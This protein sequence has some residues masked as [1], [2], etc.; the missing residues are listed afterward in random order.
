MINNKEVFIKN[1]LPALLMLV[2]V[3]SFSQLPL[4]RE[5]V[6]LQSTSDIYVAGEEIH[7][8]AAVLET[9][10]YKPST[11][12]NNMRVE[13]INNDGELIFQNNY[14][15]SGSQITSSIKLPAGLS[16]GWYHL[17]SY[18]NWMRNFPESD[19]SWLSIRVVQAADLTGK[20][21]R[22]ENDSICILLTHNGSCSNVT[23]TEE[24]SIF[25]S[26]MQGRPLSA[27]GF[28]LSSSTDTVAW[29][30]TDNTGWGVSE[31][32]KGPGD[33]YKPFIQGYAPSKTLLSINEPD[34]EK[35]VIILSDD[36]AFVYV[37]VENLLLTGSY[38][39]LVHKTYSWYW[40]KESHTVTGNIEFAVPKSSLPGGIVQFS[41][42]NN[43]NELLAARLWSDHDLNNTRVKILNHSTRKGLRS[44]YNADYHVNTQSPDNQTNINVLVMKENPFI[45]GNDYLPGLPGWA[46]GY[47]IPAAEDSFR[48]WLMNNSY[49]K[50]IVREFFRSGNSPEIPASSPTGI[51]MEY[52][53][54]T[55]NRLLSGRL[56][57]T[58]DGSGIEE[59]YLGLTILNDGT[60]HACVSD[61]KG[62]FIFS[63]PEITGPVDY[64][65]NYIREPKPEWRIDIDRLYESVRYIPPTDSVKFTE[66]ELKYL[67]EQA[68]I[69]HLKNIYSQ[70]ESDSNKN[71]DEP[72]LTGSDSYFYGMADLKV[73]VDDYIT[74]SNLREVIYEVVPYVSIRK[75]GDYTIP[76]I[77]GDHLHASLY[78]S[79]V[80]FDGIPVYDIS[81]ILDL[82][83]D[84]IK[85]IEVIN[86]FYIHGNIFFSGILNIESINRDFGGLDLPET[87]IIGTI[88]SPEGPGSDLI[89][90]ECTQEK[91]MPVLDNI[92]LW[93]SNQTEDIERITFPTGDNPGKYRINVYGYDENGN[94]V[95]ASESFK[96]E[97][98]D[99]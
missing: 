50:N 59:I 97:A 89:F 77:T 48:A 35:P 7:Y 57:N 94:W 17:R 36:R 2:T 28:I 24:C 55:H 87:S 64:I 52:L 85:T 29:I 34:N 49:P 60:F 16:T 62:Y 78:P 5:T 44:K 88:I 26:D 69:I 58:N 67:Q 1:L 79:L 82:P 8:K 13:L 73:V 75:K 19:F 56:I 96:I 3:P 68:E 39:L 80:L 41:F 51:Q 71:N 63:F 43:T 95:W 61:K 21:Y 83:P 76:V 46:A 99:Q 92:L 6:W 74:L 23:Q 11:L 90:A 27:E 18:T 98:G 10:T 20:R 86:Q 66:E 54:E 30:S 91:T 81:A 72:D 31:Y 4:L 38:R 45:A 84:R 53:P 93:K 9:D 40:Y 15:L 37:R 12:S 32:F 47:R 25:T 33:N 22:F 65:I 42:L 70:A 14:V